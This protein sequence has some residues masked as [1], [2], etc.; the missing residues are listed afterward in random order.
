MA[1]SRTRRSLAQRE[2]QPSRWLISSLLRTSTSS[3]VVGAVLLHTAEG[4]EVDRGRDHDGARGAT[5]AGAPWGEAAAS[6]EATSRLLSLNAAALSKRASDGR[7]HR[8]TANARDHALLIR[9][10]L[11]SAAAGVRAIAFNSRDAPSRAIAM[12][13]DRNF[14]AAGC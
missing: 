4:A 14:A 13:T 7:T 10:N 8:A 1:R 6:A 5:A 3:V 11:D 2:Q 12:A 9:P